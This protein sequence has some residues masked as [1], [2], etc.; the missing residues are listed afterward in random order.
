M[1]VYDKHVNSEIRWLATNAIAMNST[2]EEFRNYE[3]AL[4]YNDKTLPCT[5]LQAESAAMIAEEHMTT[6]REFPDLFQIARRWIFD[7]GA[8]KDFC[9]HRDA[10][11]FARHL[12]KLKPTRV[13]TAAGTVVMDKVVDVG[14]PWE[15]GKTRPIH[16]LPDTPTTVVHG[17]YH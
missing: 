16:I 12:R 7:S 17:N 3:A 9:G 5:T 13:G 8:S 2:F 1:P 4:E 6:E 15:T 14:L 11:K 10:E